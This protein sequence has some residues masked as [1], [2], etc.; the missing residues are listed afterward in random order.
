MACR[1]LSLEIKRPARRRENVNLLACL[2]RL[3]KINE[4]CRAREHDAPAE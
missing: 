3:L 4:G 1:P 2:S